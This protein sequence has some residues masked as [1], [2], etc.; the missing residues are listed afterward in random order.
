MT[1]GDLSLIKVDFEEVQTLAP[2]PWA[3]DA[4]WE[5]ASLQVRHRCLT[6][7][8]TLPQNIH[9]IYCPCRPV[10][11]IPTCTH[12]K[13]MHQRT[14]GQ[15]FPAERQPGRPG[16]NVGWPT[17]RRGPQRGWARARLCPGPG[18]PGEPARPSQRAQR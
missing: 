9:L 1:L 14:Q 2:L 10:S 8:L 11:G 7:P 18:A 15:L 17:G 12:P 13:D 6:P 3:P 5:K 4:A 16:A